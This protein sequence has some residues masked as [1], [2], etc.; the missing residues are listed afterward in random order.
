VTMTARLRSVMLETPLFVF[1]G[2]V[3][4]AALP[5]LGLDFYWQR[6][7]MLIAVYT[8]LCSGLNLSFGY[9]GELAL[10]QVAV[11]ASGAYAAAILFNHGHTDI[12]LAFAVATVLAGVAGLVSGIPGLR[13]SHW[14]LAL[15]SFFFVLLIPSLVT[16]LSEYTGGNAGLPGV[17]GPTLLGRP[18]FGKEFYLVAVAAT[19][20]WLLVMRNM[21]VSR[22]GTFLRV[23][24]ESPTLAE[25]LGGSVYR[26]RVQA[27]VIGALP[28]GIAGVLFT[29]MTG[30][31]SPTAF[32]LS[33]LIALLAATV[34]GGADSVWGAPVGAAILVLGPLQAASFQK[35]STAVY[36][37]FL[38][39]VGVAFSMGLAGLARLARRRLLEPRLGRAA[40]ETGHEQAGLSIPGERLEVVGVAKAFAGLKALNG[41]DLVAEPGTIT[42]IIGANGAGKTTLLNLIS[43]V[44]RADQGTVSLAGREITGLRAHRVSRLGVGR[45]FQTPLIPPRM[46]VLEVVESGRLRDGEVG[47]LTAIVRLPSH[48]RVRRQDRQAALAA[49]S[50]AGLGHL[51]HQPAGSLPL[52]TRRLLEVVRA[53]A[54]KPHVL[55]LDEPAAGLDDDGLRELEMLMRRTREAG[56]TVVLVEHNVP[57]V[58]D[59]AD[60][61]FAMELGRV[62]ASGPPD[63]VRRDQKVIDSYLGR[64]GQVAE[65]SGVA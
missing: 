31:I 28:A 51:A 39:F 6:Q 22:F 32:T 59:V 49:L 48:Y 36:G 5:Y 17:L 21:V 45:T 14:S 61:V 30:F 7:V 40:A 37:A 27:Y 33:L 13:L 26:L 50:F 18:L 29:Y 38:I 52:G 65:S 41:V 11:F 58:M 1:V 2:F 34:L 4:A 15:V 47:L 62:I 57:F 43:G 44:L 56:G 53:V 19:L 8:L 46:T 63:V 25:S 10:G 9:A 3:L 64:R 54:G 42:A 12:L 20:L 60:Q 23:M 24:A 35:Y 55:L 16:I